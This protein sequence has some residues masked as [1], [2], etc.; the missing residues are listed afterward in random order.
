MSIASFFGLRQGDG[1][2]PTCMVS[3]TNKTPYSSTLEITLT[4]DVVTLDFSGTGLNFG[5]N[6]GDVTLHD[7]NFESISVDG[8]QVTLVKSQ[9]NPT[10]YL[11]L[12]TVG[13]VGLPELDGLE[14]PPCYYEIINP[15]ESPTFVPTSSPTT[16]NNP[17]Q[18]PSSFPTTKEP[19][20]TTHTSETYSPTSPTH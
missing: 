1:L 8:H 19:T 3:V 16:S 5:D 4:S 13:G 9:W 18:A 7:A 2:D 12:V 11:T 17:T 6:A 20:S 15:T 10:G 14:A